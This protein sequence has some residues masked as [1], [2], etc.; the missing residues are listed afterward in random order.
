MPLRL[1]PEQYMLLCRKILQRDNWRCRSCQ[2]RSNLHVHHIVFRSQGGLDDDKNL[3][4]V[5]NS[6]HEGIHTAIQDGTFGLSLLVTD[7]EAGAN[8]HV[9]FLRS[10]WWRPK[11]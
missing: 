11:Q 10:Y 8:S 3:I 5:C 6:C 1:P 2:L 4:T 9:T 7:E